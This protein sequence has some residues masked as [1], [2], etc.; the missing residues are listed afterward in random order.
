MSLTACWRALGTIDDTTS[1]TATATESTCMIKYETFVVAAILVPL[2]Q[3][4]YYTNCIEMSQYNVST[5]NYHN[6]RSLATWGTVRVPGGPG[7]V[8]RIERT[9][10]ME[11]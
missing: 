1:P 5:R 7:G 11:W 3:Y 2:V 6:S 4:F 8:Y 10:T 9:S